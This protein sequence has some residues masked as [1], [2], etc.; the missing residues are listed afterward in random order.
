MKHLKIALLALLVVATLNNANAQDKEN[1]W[2]LTFGTN[3]IDISTPTDAKSGYFGSFD[4]DGNNLHI[5]PFLS[6]VAATRYLDKGF[7][8]ELAGS[9]NRVD[10]PWG[11]GSETSHAAVDLNVKYDLNNAFGET[12]WFDPFVYLGVGE[13]W[14]GAKDG[15]GLNV[16]AGFNAWF[17]KSLGL[18]FTS[19]YKKVNTPVDFKMF[20][21][22]VGLTWR[23][24]KNDSDG[25]GVRNKE[26]KC[27]DLAGTAELNGCPDMDKDKDGVMDCCDK[28]PDVAGVAALGGCPDADGDGITDADDEC[29]T[30]AGP[31]KLNG[32]PDRD[33]DH[34]ADKNDGCPDVPGPTTNA[35]CPFK[36]TD[37]DGVIDLIDNCVTVPGPA[38]NHGCPE[39]FKDASSID[40]A[41][42]GI[43]FDTGKS[44]IRT[45]IAVILDQV[46]EVLNQNQN[47][48]FKFAV[49]GHTDNTGSA[50]KNLE[51]SRAR[52]ASVKDYLVAK[53][54]SANRLST[55]GFGQN[56]PIDTNNTAAGRLNNRRVEIKE[57]K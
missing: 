57:V 23:F 35:G 11:S 51:L 12:G 37:G 45:D 50:A 31:K 4:Y 21:H 30:V 42:K 40:I 32:C 33:G 20:Q 48:Q 9:Y 39:T 2:M 49:N 17:N 54:V 22:S 5:L 14:I 16:G 53:G 24:G 19:G 46:A 18:N 34:V 43:N 27:P 3:A 29:P 36:D 44:N 28:C 10:R 8:L 38:K 26:D 56:Q 1:P 15:V 13:N 6:R 47:L 55:E 41:A 52:A 25:D 7:S